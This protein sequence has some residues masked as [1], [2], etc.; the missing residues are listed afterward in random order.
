MDVAMKRDIAAMVIA[1]LAKLR[2]RLTVIFNSPIRL[3]SAAGQSGPL[4]G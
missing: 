3:Y 2:L 4:S 1:T